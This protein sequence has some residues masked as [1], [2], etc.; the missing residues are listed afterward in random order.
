VYCR[1][2]YK[3]VIE[4]TPEAQKLSAALHLGKTSNIDQTGKGLQQLI[5]LQAMMTLVKIR[6]P[7]RQSSYRS[8][9]LRVSVPQKRHF[10]TWIFKSI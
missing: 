2:G 8:D 7:F 4:I 5:N 3:E 6:R 9:H 1:L 10:H